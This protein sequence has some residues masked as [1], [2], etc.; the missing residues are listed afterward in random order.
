MQDN[1]PLH[2]LIAPIAFLLGT[3]DGEGRGLWTSDPIFRY[4]ERIEYTH[5]GGPFIA[6]HQT[7]TTLDGTKKL[8]TEAGYIRAGPE[9]TIEMVIAQPTGLVE[10]HTGLLVGQRLDLRSLSVSRTPTA[11]AVTNVVR[12]VEVTGQVLDYQMN[13]AMHDEPVAPHLTAKLQR[14]DQPDPVPPTPMSST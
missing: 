3:W 14:V 11:L 1:P 7:T 4:R 9:H 2:H 6:Y 10:V 5:Q 13:L 12:L 8:H